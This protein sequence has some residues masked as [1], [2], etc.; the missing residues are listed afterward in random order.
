MG[1][2][3]RRT[4]DKS[5]PVAL[6]NQ[7]KAAISKMKSTWRNLLLD[8]LPQVRQ[9][10]RIPGVGRRRTSRRPGGR[11][12][13]GNGGTFVQASRNT[14]WRWRLFLRSCSS[15]SGRLTA[16]NRWKEKRRWHLSDNKLIAALDKKQV[17][18]KWM[19]LFQRKD[20]QQKTKIESRTSSWQL[21]DRS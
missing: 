13:T 10:D 1:D 19:R 11:D 20:T 21:R 15:T 16:R 4:C 14:G 6:K 18:K 12:V 17:Q 2:D 9:H 3:N 8:C 5:R 7:E